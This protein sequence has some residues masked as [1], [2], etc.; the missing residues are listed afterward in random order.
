MYKIN[1]ITNYQ[2]VTCIYTYTKTLLH[3]LIKGTTNNTILSE[4]FSNSIEKWS[5]ETK[6]I[7]HSYKLLNRSSYGSYDGFFDRCGPIVTP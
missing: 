6:L 7:P 5:K 4:K 1:S 3:V 2:N